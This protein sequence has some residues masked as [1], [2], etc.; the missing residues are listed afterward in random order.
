M[1]AT[2]KS[3][4]EDMVLRGLKTG[5]RVWTMPL[6]QDYKK[7]LA[8]VHADIVNSADGFG[9]A[10]TAALFLQYF[11]SHKKWLHFDLYAWKDQPS[12]CFTE[13]GASGQPVQTV[14]EYLKTQ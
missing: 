3:V 4:A 12:G 9:G 5:D 8:S 11:V 6:I 2:D 10:V 14:I 13:V 1:F 7:Q